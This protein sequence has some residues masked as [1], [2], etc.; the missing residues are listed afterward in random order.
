MHDASPVRGLD[1]GCHL[2]AD[3]QD[4]IHAEALAAVA[5]IEAGP[6][7]VLHGQ[8]G[9]AALRDFRLENRHDVRVR[10]QLRHQVRFGLETAACTL[11]LQVGQ[12]HLD[13]YFTAR[14]VLLVQVHVR[15]A[16]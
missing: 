1:G 14:P 8:V 2:D 11:G 12:Q 10:G 15:E 3:G 5:H 6:G 7:A 13:G 9:M 4:L 16:T